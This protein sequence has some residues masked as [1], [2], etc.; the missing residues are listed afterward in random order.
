[1]AIDLFENYVE[2]R[3]LDLEEGK[4]LNLLELLRKN[5]LEAYDRLQKKKEK[6]EH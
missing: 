6:K 1:M 4:D 5:L 3:G 2:K